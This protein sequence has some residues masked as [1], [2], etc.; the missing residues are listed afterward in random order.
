[1]TSPTHS[2]HSILWFGIGMIGLLFGA[3]LLRFWGLGRFNTLVFDEVYFVKFANHYLLHAPFFDAHPPLGKYLIAMGMWLTDRL[4]LP[5][6]LSLNDL[7]G[8][9][10]SPISYRW[11]N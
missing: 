3:A 7:S 1:M 2:S 11:M 6:N 4:P 8:S 10:R 5:S 9:L